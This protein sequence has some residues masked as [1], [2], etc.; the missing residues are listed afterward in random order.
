MQAL[1]HKNQS[2]LF[3][4]ISVDEWVR[5]IRWGNKV[6]TLTMCLMISIGSI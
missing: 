1:L 2:D 5:G 3:G 6:K 4:I